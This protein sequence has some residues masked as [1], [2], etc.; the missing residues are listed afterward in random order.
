VLYLTSVHIGYQRFLGALHHPGLTHTPG[1][2]CQPMPVFPCRD[3]ALEPHSKRGLIFYGKRP[4]AKQLDRLHPCQTRADLTNFSNDRRQVVTQK[5]LLQY[6]CCLVGDSTAPAPASALPPAPV[7][8][9]PQAPAPATAQAPAADPTPTSSE[10]SAALPVSAS[11]SAKG[12]KTSNKGLIAGIFFAGVGATL[13]VLLVG[14]FGFRYWRTD[15]SASPPPPQRPLNAPSPGAPVGQTPW[16]IT[17][18]YQSQA[19][20]FMAMNPPKPPAPWPIN[21]DDGAAVVGPGASCSSKPPPFHA[22]LVG[23]GSL[24]HGY[25][26]HDRGAPQPPHAAHAPS[27]YTG[28]GLF[29]GSSHSGAPPGQLPLR[30]M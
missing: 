18:E 9:R 21:R 17:P 29:A 24:Q 15:S 3:K 11:L 2:L 27:G 13:V 14:L 5:K 25:H 16:Y 26:A 10:S 7:I 28:G 4:L 8:A 20:Q 22:A 30:Y 12:K 1:H 19:N 23:G 6:T